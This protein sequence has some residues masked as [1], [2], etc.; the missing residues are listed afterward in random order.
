MTTNASSPRP[1]A[2]KAIPNGPLQVKGTF[3][4]RGAD[5]DYDLD[6]QAIVLLCRC[7]RSGNQPFCD[8]SHKRTGWTSDDQ[9]SAAPTVDRAE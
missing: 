6:G 1:V 7:G 3:T 4:L 8:S 5:G 9:P 2:V